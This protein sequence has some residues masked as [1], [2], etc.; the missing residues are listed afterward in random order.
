MAT[1]VGDMPKRAFAST[2]KESAGSKETEDHE[3]YPRDAQARDAQSRLG[4]SEPGEAPSP[5]AAPGP[6]QTDFTLVRST[7]DRPGSGWRRALFVATG[8]VINPG[9]GPAEQRRQDLE[10]RIR[11]QLP[12]HRQ[13]AVASIKGGVGKTTLSAVLGLLLA[14]HR[15]DRVVALDADTDAGT[16]ADRLTGEPSVTVRDLLDNIDG[17]G[18]LPDLARF[19]SLAGRLQVV[20][21][22]QDPAMSRA[23]DRGD[24][25]QVCAV[26]RRF[27]DIIV[28]DSGTGVLHSAMD[29]ILATADSLVVV[30]SPTVDGAS[31]ASKTLDWLVAHGHHDVVER[32]VV[33]LS[34]DRT[35]DEVDSTQLRTHFAARC[36]AVVEVPHDAHLAA[37]GRIELGALRPATAD[38]FLEVAALVADD[39][40]AA[41]DR[42][43]G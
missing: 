41:T 25:E 7:S 29:G 23:F 31:R 35:S 21:S 42:T 5:A 10:E 2:E 37:G 40:G 9:I 28:V 22:E 17:I 20:A 32:A 3:E 34:A 27:F 6:E 14:E 19:A 11:R 18:A 36:R 4:P 26:L 12:G 43:V 24:Y 33:V 13:I 8:G 30:G 38:A 1:R 39:F 15:G 16:L